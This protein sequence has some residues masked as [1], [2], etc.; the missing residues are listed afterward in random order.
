M[1]DEIV[2]AVASVRAIGEITGPPF[3]LS[4]PLVLVSDPVCFSLEGFGFGTFGKGACERVNVLVNVFSPVRGLRK[5]FD[6]EADG[7]FKFCWESGDRRLRDPQGELPCG[8]FTIR[9]GVVR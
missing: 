6:L 4:M 3:K 8:Y 9:R 1:L 7:A 2:F 5:P